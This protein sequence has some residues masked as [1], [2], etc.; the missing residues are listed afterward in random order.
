MF[1]DFRPGDM[2]SDRFVF[3]Q[4]TPDSYYRMPACLAV[5]VQTMCHTATTISENKHVMLRNV[6]VKKSE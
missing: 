6:P 2:Y 4:E 3:S 5:P 1:S